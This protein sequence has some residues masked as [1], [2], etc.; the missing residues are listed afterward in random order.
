MARGVERPQDDGATS[1][2]AA[3]EIGVV[4]WDVLV[5]PLEQAAE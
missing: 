1:L 5:A 2:M 3:E 4:E